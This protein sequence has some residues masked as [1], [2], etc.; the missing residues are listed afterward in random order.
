MRMKSVQMRI[1][2]GAALCLL[3][4]AGAI[5]GYSAITAN[6]TAVNNAESQVM[7]TAR[8]QAAIVDAELEVAMDA[9]RTLAQAFAAAK[10]GEEGLSRSQVNAMLKQVLSE[11]LSF[12]G[13][14][15]LWEPNAFDGERCRLRWPRWIR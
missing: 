8:E 4:V 12:L 6:Q 10:T 11:N 9:A 13:V 14:Y 5:T 15:T 3:L 2:L 7:A 1:V